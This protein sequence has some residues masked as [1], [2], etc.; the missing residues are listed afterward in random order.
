[1]SDGKSPLLANGKGL[2]IYAGILRQPKR[3]ILV[4]YTGYAGNV[5]NVLS[6]LLGSV[7]SSAQRTSLKLSDGKHALHHFTNLP[8]S[9][10]FVCLAEVGMGKDTPFNLLVKLEEQ[11]QQQYTSQQVE[12]AADG[13]MQSDFEEN[14][15]RLVDTANGQPPGDQRTAKLMD[16][17]EAVSDNLHEA[18]THILEREDRINALAQNAERIATSSLTLREEA[19]ALHRR[20]WWKNTRL[21]VCGAVVVLVVVVIIVLDFVT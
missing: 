16:K 2:I 7:D 14:L 10:S 19:T 17:V 18:M 5:K 20:V 11:F 6:E 3:R 1:M 9:V 4:E 12:S 21:L 8:L 15:R 13:G